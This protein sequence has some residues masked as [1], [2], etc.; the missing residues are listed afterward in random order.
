MKRKIVSLLIISAMTIS[1]LAGCGGESSK[2]DKKSEGSSEG[3]VYLMNFK[4]EDAETFETLVMPKFT[5]ETGIEAEV[6]TAAANTYGSSL[7]AEMAKED[8]PTLFQMSGRSAIDSWGDYALDLS[9]TD[10]YN[11]LTDKSL[12]VTDGETDKVYAVPYT[13]EGYG[14]IAN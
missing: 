4:P 11:R 8:A 13:V 12:A 7:K 2:A 6:M 14:I 10:F 1:M 9:G 5:E 3:K